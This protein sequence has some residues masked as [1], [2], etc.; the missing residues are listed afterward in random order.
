M[1]SGPVTN[2][3]PL[4]RPELSVSSG[5]LRLRTITLRLPSFLIALKLRAIRARATVL[6]APGRRPRMPTW[7]AAPA[8]DAGVDAVDVAEDGVDRLQLDPVAAH[9][10]VAG[11]DVLHDAGEDVP[12][13]GAPRCKRWA[14]VER[15]FRLG[16]AHL[17]RRAE[18]LHSIPQREHA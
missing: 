2:R 13:V 9:G 18:C 17:D 15:V 8:A 10:P 12:V 6:P 3:N 11:D 7:P 4:L 14:V 1:N 16:G 5:G